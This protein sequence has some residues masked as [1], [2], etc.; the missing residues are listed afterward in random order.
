[1]ASTNS[2]AIFPSLGHQVLSSLVHLLGILLSLKAQERSAQRCHP[3][4]SLLA[5]CFARRFSLSNMGLAKYEM[6]LNVLVH[7]LRLVVGS[8]FWP[9]SPI[10]EYLESR[11]LQLL[12]LIR[13]QVVVRILWY[14]FLI[15][16]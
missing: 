5:A 6:L 14:A 15:L 10:R 16:Q 12:T 4:C 11:R 2:A 8:A 13:P 1:M 7:F 9:S 3:G